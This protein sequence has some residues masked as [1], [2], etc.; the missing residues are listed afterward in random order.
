MKIKGFT[1]LEALITTLLVGIMA[2][3]GIYIVSR[4]SKIVRDN[5]NEVTARNNANRIIMEMI[6]DIKEAPYMYSYYNSTT[7]T[8]DYLV[9]YKGIG[10]LGSVWYF[11]D[12]K[13]R[14]YRPEYG[15]YKPYNIIG[16]YDYNINANIDVTRLNSPYYRVAIDMKLELLDEAGRSFEMDSLN[17]VCY[18]RM[19]PSGHGWSNL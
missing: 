18:N 15:A 1:L 3:S 6:R 4:S 13:L 2:T 14:V 12:N 8:I 9:T 16:S 17:T 7:S 11:S 5:F 19:D 10:Q